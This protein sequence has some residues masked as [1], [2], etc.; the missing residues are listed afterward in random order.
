MCSAT[1]EVLV[2]GYPVALTPAELA[3]LELLMT[4]R[5]HGVTTEAIVEAARLDESS[6]EWTDPDAIVARLRRKTRVRGRGQA[7]RKE[8]V[9]LYF[10]GDDAEGGAADG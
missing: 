1:G 8:R 9:Q 6:D 5:G 7:V 3:V 10:F 2:G 4:N